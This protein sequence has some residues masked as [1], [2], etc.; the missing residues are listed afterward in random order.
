FQKLF[1]TVNNVPPRVF[2]GGAEVVH[3]DEVMHHTGRVTDSGADTWTATVNYGDGSGTQPLTV[4]PDGT[5]LFAHLYQRP[6]RYRVT[7]SVFDDDGD[8]SSDTF[9][10]IVPP[11]H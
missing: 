1:V 9:V 5:L 2:L 6:G 10:V 11:R 8:V 4:Q 3:V 7:V